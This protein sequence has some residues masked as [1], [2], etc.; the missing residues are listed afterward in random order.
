MNPPEETGIASA[1]EIQKETEAEE[2]K[3]ESQE[4]L[5]NHKTRRKQETQDIFRKILEAVGKEDLREAEFYA[6]I[7]L[8]KIGQWKKGV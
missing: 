2:E 1:Q 4:V 7:L 8:D 5:E 6:K 3:T